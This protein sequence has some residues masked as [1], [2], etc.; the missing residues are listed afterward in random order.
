MEIIIV[1]S[2]YGMFGH[3]LF[4]FGFNEITI[5][6]HETQVDIVFN[7]YSLLKWETVKYISYHQ[8]Q[9]GYW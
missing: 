8:S 3:Q 9:H 1:K 2:E 6:E 7:I 5:Q 4:N